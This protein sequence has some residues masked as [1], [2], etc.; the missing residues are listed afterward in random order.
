VKFSVLALDFDGD[1]GERQRERRSRY[2]AIASS[3]LEVRELE[4]LDRRGEVVDL[5]TA[6]VESVSLRY[7]VGISGSTEA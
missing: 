2:S 6:L 5:V 7:E 1:R 3:R 4:E